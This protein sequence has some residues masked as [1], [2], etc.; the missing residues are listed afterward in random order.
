MTIQCLYKNG[1]WVDICKDHERGVFLGALELVMMGAFMDDF[2]F[3]TLLQ[4]VDEKKKVVWFA[5]VTA[6]RDSVM[7]GPKPKVEAFYRKNNTFVRARD[8]LPQSPAS[9]A[10]AAK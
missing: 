5:K 4:R 9:V 6:F 8:L 10:L 2:T 1:E 7:D 3:L